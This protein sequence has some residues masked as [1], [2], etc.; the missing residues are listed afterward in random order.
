M[1]GLT[2]SYVNFDSDDSRLLFSILKD[3]DCNFKTFSVNPFVGY[4]LADNLIDS[5]KLGYSHT[6]ADLGNVSLNIDDDLNF[7]LDNIRYTENL[8]SIGIFHRSYVGLDRGKL[9]GLFN[10]QQLTDFYVH[11]HIQTRH[12]RYLPELCVHHYSYYIYIWAYAL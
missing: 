3:F 1:G 2:F 11:R 4:A 7:S 10:E 9:F 5:M 12:S 8:R 6:I